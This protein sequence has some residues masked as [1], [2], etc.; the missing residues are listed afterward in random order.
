MKN[1]TYD[2]V[3]QNEIRKYIKKNFKVQTKYYPLI[4]EIIYRRAILFKFNRERILLDLERGAKWLEAVDKEIFSEEKM[5]FYGFY[6][7]NQRKIT[8]NENRLNN[9]QDGLIAFCFFAHEFT[10]AICK[11][12]E[13]DDVLEFR[14]LIEGKKG[15]YNVYSGLRNR[16]LLEIIATKLSEV[17]IDFGYFNDRLQVSR[18]YNS[19]NT[20]SYANSSPILEMIELAY[21]MNEIEFLSHAA[22]GRDKLA[23]ILAQ[24]IGTNKQEA[25]DELDQIELQYQVIHLFLYNNNPT[26]YDDLGKN[27]CGIYKKCSD[28]MI[29]R[30]QNTNINSIEEARAYIEQ[31]KYEYNKLNM[32]AK[33]IIYINRPNIDALAQSA[34]IP[35]GINQF[36]KDFFKTINKEQSKMFFRIQYMENAIN[37]NQN[38]ITHQEALYRFNK[39]RKEGIRA[40]ILSHIDFSSYEFPISR[41]TIYNNKENIMIWDNNRI[42]KK[43]LKALNPRFWQQY[44][45]RRLKEVFNRDKNTA[46][47]LGTGKENQGRTDY[48]DIFKGTTEWPETRHEKFVSGLD[49]TNSIYSN[50][51]YSHN[52]YGYSANKRDITEDKEVS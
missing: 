7:T 14:Y 48:S 29:K 34:N 31:L 37:I 26:T 2:F 44:Y 47:L 10:H 22:D 45:L 19:R 38:G 18:Y 11:D 32:L 51:P 42:A 49:P 6:K 16:F 24:R 1:K 12:E 43:A 50:L 23:T 25:Y 9:L 39:I 17:I 33:K 21:G 3:S 28:L 40:T 27:F 52:L 4:E 13:G 8:F 46:Y 36:Y 15:R 30:M 41:D 20:F 5:N 35:N